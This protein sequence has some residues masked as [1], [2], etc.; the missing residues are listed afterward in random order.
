[1]ARLLTFFATIGFR[2]K[3]YAVLAVAVLIALLKVRSDIA[4]NAA[5]K[6]ARKMEN[7]DKKRADQIRRAAD[8]AGSRDRVR[9]PDDKRGFRD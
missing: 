2:L 5:E 1:M 6:Y 9:P 8:R 7:A 3:A 4:R